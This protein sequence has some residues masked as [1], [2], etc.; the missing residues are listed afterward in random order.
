[1][2]TASMTSLVR[3]RRRLAS[4][5]RMPQ[6]LAVSYAT[7]PSSRHDLLARTRSALCGRVGPALRG[8]VR[9]EGALR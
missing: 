7:G 8:R 9:L 4:G 1:M 2:E 6:L 5:H 3:M